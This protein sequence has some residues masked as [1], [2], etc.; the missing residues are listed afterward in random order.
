MET[1]SV[2]LNFILGSGLIGT[3]IF[4]SSSRRKA[5]AEAETAEIN[6]QKERTSAERENIAFL[7]SQLQEAWSEVE[8]MQNI[9]NEKREQ[10][11]SMMRQTKQLEIEL[12]EQ[13]AIAKRASLLSCANAQCASRKQL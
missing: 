9:I 3:V 6:S 10:I 7:S 8:K 11:I 2:I 1:L 4:Y 12:I 5:N 13:N